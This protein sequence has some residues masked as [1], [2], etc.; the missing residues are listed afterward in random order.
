MTTI[1]ILS[2]LLACGD[3][4]QDTDAGTDTDTVVDDGVTQDDFIYVSEEPVGSQDC[5]VG[6][7]DAVGSWNTQTLIDFS[8]DESFEAV[9]NVDVNVIDFETDEPVSEATV[10]VYY[11][12]EL[13]GAPDVQGESDTAGAL[14]LDVP[15]CSPY[16]YRVFTDPALDE[17]RITIEAHTIEKPSVTATEFNSVSKGTYQVIPSLLGVAVDP[18]KGIVAGTMYD[19]NGDKVVGAQVVVKNAAGEIPESLVVNYFVDDF[20]NRNQEYTSEDGLWVASNVPV[21]EWNVEA[22]VSAGDGAHI[23]VGATQIQVFANSINISNIHLGFGDGLK[24][25]ADCVTE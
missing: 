15:V 6:G 7:F 21:G 8:E 9:K 2:G 22:Y 24:Y 1:W 12:D 4:A 17:T 23:M 10:E 13:S 25:P 3:K 18:D 20:P 11:A 16:S 5:F 19:C 14:S